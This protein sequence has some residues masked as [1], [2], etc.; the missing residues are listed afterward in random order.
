MRGD[1]LTRTRKLVKGLAKAEPIW[2]KPM[3][4]APPAIFPGA[5][6]KVQ[7]I[8]LP[9]DPYKNK[10]FKK[11]PDAKLEDTIKFCGFD[12]SP[13]RVFGRRV[14][15]LKEQGV[16]EEEAMALANMECVEERKAKKKAYARLKQIAHIQRKRPPRNPYASAIK[17]IQAEERKFIRDRL[18]NPSSRQIV[19]R[20]KGERLAEIQDR[21]RGGW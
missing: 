12:P 19:K 9:E 4:Q 16:P 18:F 14:L 15:E 20:L 3:E 13:A 7:K 1:L 17:E 8:G 11:H 5:D 21:Q 2:L 10:F 6:G